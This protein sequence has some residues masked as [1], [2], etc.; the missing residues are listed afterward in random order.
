[1]LLKFLAALLFF[2]V[3]A[4]AQIFGG[5]DLLNLF[6]V[7]KE[8]EPNII[9]PYQIIK[10]VDAWEWFKSIS[11]A[12]GLNKV[13]VGMIDTGIDSGHQ[14][15]NNPKVDFGN[16]PADALTDNFPG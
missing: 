5:W 12:P 7:L 9:K 6:G 4:N 16:T 14:E 3:V 8:T 13:G 2:P 15:F 10:A 1:M 11:P